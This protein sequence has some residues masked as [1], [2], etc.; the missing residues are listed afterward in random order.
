[1]AHKRKSKNKSAFNGTGPEVAQPWFTKNVE[2]AKR[3]KAMAK[4]S[5]KKNR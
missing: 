3:R 1:M 4:Q 5:R 2:R